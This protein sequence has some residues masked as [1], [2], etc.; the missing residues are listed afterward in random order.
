[1]GEVAAGRVDPMGR[2][3]PSEDGWYWARH[4][5][6]GWVI[7][8]FVIAEGVPHV[9]DA[10]QFGWNVLVDQFQEWN[11]NRIPDRQD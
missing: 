7:T 8:H 5:V 10:G 11:M 6:F 3:I 4:K 2:S 1:M 9:Q